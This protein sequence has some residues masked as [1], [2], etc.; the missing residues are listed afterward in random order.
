M[1][2]AWLL[3]ALLCVF[4]AAQAA[5]PARTLTADIPAAGVTALKLS[6]D[7][8]QAEIGVSPD[9]AVHVRVTLKQKQREF[10][11]FFHW[12]SAGTARDIAAATL[13]SSRE[14]G[15]VSVALSY[16][17]IDSGDVQQ[18]WRVELPARLA[19][20]AT[21]KVGRLG[22]DGIAGG[23]TARLN[24]GQLDITSP[25]GPLHVEVNVGQI[26]ARSHSARH[27]P[28]RLA[29]NIGEAALYMDGKRVGGAG[30][31]SG[32]GRTL[33]LAGSGPDSMDLKVNIGEV[34]LRLR[35]EASAGGAH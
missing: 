35:P 33:S 22:I 29:S 28:I 32:L 7:V 9:D 3:G 14:G 5:A 17:D 26:R 16:P 13:S 1:S 24:V 25:A 18:N 8:G 30:G 31:H 12:M 11:W 27:G 4:Q 21:M 20:D 6:M 10:L 2:R 19:L 23:I 15:T 34:L